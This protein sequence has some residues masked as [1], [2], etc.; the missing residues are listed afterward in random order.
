DAIALLPA[1]DV[2]L[3]VAQ[4]SVTRSDEAREVGDMLRR[5]RAPVL[6]VAFTNV[7]RKERSPQGRGTE[8][9]PQGP[10]ASVVLEDYD[11]PRPAESAPTGRLW[12]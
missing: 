11:I 8:P 12:L 2:V 3:V 4:Y 1:V 9:M 5:F 7:P 10:P 6:G